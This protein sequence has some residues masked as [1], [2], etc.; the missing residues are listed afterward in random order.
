MITNSKE[1]F[2]RAQVTSDVQM[3]ELTKQGRRGWLYRVLPITL[4]LLCISFWSL[5]AATG[6]PFSA[7]FSNS[8]MLSTKYSAEPG[9]VMIARIVMLF[10]VV[11][12][13]F[14]LYNTFQETG[15]ISGFLLGPELSKSTLANV[16]A[17]SKAQRMDAG[18]KMSMTLMAK[19]LLDEDRNSKES[20][21]VPVS[22]G[23]P[24][25]QG[26]AGGG[27]GEA[28]A[29]A[30]SPVASS[31]AASGPGIVFQSPTTGQ[32]VFNST[33]GGGAGAAGAAQQGGTAGGGG[34]GAFK[35]PL[36]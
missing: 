36:A 22:Q 35:A 2:T 1:S 8:Q 7:V 18:S 15:T 24:V 17:V 10:V 9:K 30:A 21:K 31:A 20:E 32:V 29:A 27:G 16:S 23:F 4:I 26:Q 14:F 19:H 13:V 3:E 34:M 25:S 6:I 11:G 33:G 5:S 12:C 28:R